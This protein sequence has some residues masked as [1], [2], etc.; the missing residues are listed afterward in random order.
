MKTDLLTYAL[1]L[2]GASDDGGHLTVA[3]S[4]GAVHVQPAAGH[5][6]V[7]DTRTGQDAG[8]REAVSQAALREAVTPQAPLNH[9]GLTRGTV[10]TALG[11][12]AFTLDRKNVLPGDT[13]LCVR[14]SDRTVVLG[15]VPYDDLW[16]ARSAAQPTNN[17]PTVIRRTD[18]GRHDVPTRHVRN[19]LW[20]LL[21]G[22]YPQ[23]VTPRA[24]WAVLVEEAHA[25]VQ[26]AQ[27]GVS[28]AQGHL[29]R[30]RAALQDLQAQ[31]WPSSEPLAL[32]Q[33]F[34]E[35]ILP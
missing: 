2:L 7:R 35:L 24:R 10:V 19:V 11:P 15:G 29:D 8:E 1:N 25:A 12:L 28:R 13:R 21:E 20:T 14:L 33:P 32:S 17:L 6:K 5:L 23:L 18:S 26:D 34:K 4:F 9:L 31:P 3:D 16:T 27:A 22:L 30:T